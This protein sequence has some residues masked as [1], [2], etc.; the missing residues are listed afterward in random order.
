MGVSLKN[1]RNH[2]LD[3]F[4]ELKEVG[5]QRDTIHFLM[6]PPRKNSSPSCRYKGLVDAR[7]P[8]KRNCYRQDSANQHFLS[9]RVAY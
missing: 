8:T 3:Q 2:L 5:I 9:A 7:V 1:I 6:A 4:P